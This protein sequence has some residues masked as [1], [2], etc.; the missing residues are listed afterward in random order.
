MSV[1]T[2]CNFTKVNEY[3]TTNHLL[4]LTIGLIQEIN[5]YSHLKTKLENLV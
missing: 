2:W 1:E 3:S 5:R 4:K